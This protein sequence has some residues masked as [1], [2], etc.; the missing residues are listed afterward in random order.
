MLAKFLKRIGIVCVVFC[1]HVGCLFAERRPIRHYLPYETVFSQTEQQRILSYLADDQA[2]GRMTGTWANEMVATYI[3]HEME[4]YGLLPFF[5]GGYTQRFLIDSL[6]GFNIAG[7]IPAKTPTREYLIISAH[8]DH[9]GAINGHVY[10]GADDNAS[11]VTALLNLAKMFAKMDE[12]GE[13]VDMNLVFVAFDGKERSMAG[14]QYFIRHLDM[15]YRDVQCNI[16]LDQIGSVLEPVE[17]GKPEFIMVLGDHTLPEGTRH[18]LGTCNRIYQ[19]GLDIHNSFYGSE[20]FTEIMYGLSDQA[21]F[22]KVNIPAL[23]FTSGFTKHTYKTTDDLQYID[24]NVL[25]KRTL[26]V[27]YFVQHFAQCK[28]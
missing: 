14:S 17:K 4:S 3:R 12:Q 2:R 9:M 15:L 13:G 19:L 18:L 22:Q 7:W 5:N 8:Y 20:N 10:N 26:L 28:R 27:F 25:R 16:N 23:L 21:S 11:G 6:K 24:F 1:L